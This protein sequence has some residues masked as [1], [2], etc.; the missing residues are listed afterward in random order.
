MKPNRLFNRSAIICLQLCILLF[1]A[2]N[3]YAGTA[4][5]VGGTITYSVGGSPASATISAYVVGRPGEEIP[6]VYGSGTYEVQCGDF[7]TDWTAGEVLHVDVDDG[8]GG[9]ASGEVTL[10][11]NPSDVLNIV[12]IPPTPPAPI[13]GTITQPTCSVSTGSVQLNGL[14]SSGT[15]TITTYPGGATTVGS[16]TTTTISGLASGTYTFTVTNQQGGISD[17]SAE[18]VINPQP[19]I[20]AQPGAITGPLAVCEGNPETYKPGNLQHI[21]CFRGNLLYLDS[22]LGMEY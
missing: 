19:T 16:G 22:S 1:S 3:L 5:I 14:P 7:P 12:I 17:H 15:W 20:P 9:I 11:S 18:A 13:I 8:L 21:C 10:T 2:L 4:H 6:G